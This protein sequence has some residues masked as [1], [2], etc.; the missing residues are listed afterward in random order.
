MAGRKIPH[1]HIERKAYR[2]RDRDINEACLYFKEMRGFSA[3]Q[4]TLVPN[5]AVKALSPSAKSIGTGQNRE[6][7]A[8]LDEDIPKIKLDFEPSAKRKPG[9]VLKLY[10]M[11]THTS[12]DRT[13]TSYLVLSTMLS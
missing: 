8:E 9:Q 12:L 11:S 7:T 1:R 3:V 6:Q 5:I 4:P 10:T 2:L 13:G